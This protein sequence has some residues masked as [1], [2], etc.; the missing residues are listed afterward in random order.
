MNIHIFGDIKQKWMYAY[1][2]YLKFISRQK[3]WYTKYIYK[4][5]YIYI[6]IYIILCNSKD[7]NFHSIISNKKIL[8]IC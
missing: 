4:T 6:N 8:Q 3:I 2:F 5:I 1:N 7:T